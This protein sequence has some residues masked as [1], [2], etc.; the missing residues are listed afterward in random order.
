MYFNNLQSLR[1]EKELTQSDV[2]EIL[3][4]KRSTYNNWEC[5]LVMIPLDMADKLSCFYKVKLS[6]IY[7]I[8]KESVKV[9]NIKR[10]DYDKMLITLNRLKFE[11]NHTYT[12]IADN[13]KC[14]VSTVQRYF[15]GVFFPPV[16]RLVAL[17]NLYNMDL[18]TL[19]GKL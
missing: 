6:Y 18:D 3:N 1:N 5:G 14:N 16:D 2:S 12:Y 4:R 9:E 11:Q 10:I 8:E 19:C 15:K 7:G 17:A 13:L